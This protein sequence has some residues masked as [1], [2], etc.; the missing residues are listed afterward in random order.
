MLGYLSWNHQ[1]FF[2][3]AALKHLVLRMLFLVEVPMSIELNIFLLSSYWTIFIVALSWGSRVLVGVMLLDL[4]SVFMHFNEMHTRLSSRKKGCL[5]HLNL[6]RLEFLGLWQNYLVWINWKTETSDI[7]KMWYKKT[8][9]RLTGENDKPPF[10]IL[11]FPNINSYSYYFLN[12]ILVGQ[13]TRIPL[14]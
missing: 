2:P 14:A 1:F 6:S 12:L 7:H 9:F 10:I 8:I 3:L 11:F 5:G 13:G 4:L